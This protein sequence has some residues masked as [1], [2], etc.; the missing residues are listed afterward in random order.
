M[1]GTCGYLLCVGLQQDTGGHRGVTGIRAERWDLL[2]RFPTHGGEHL[3]QR[4]HGLAGGSVEVALCCE[5]TQI[6]LLLCALDQAWV[7]YKQGLPRLSFL[8]TVGTECLLL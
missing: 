8:V 5:V 2:L 4:G 6:F 3:A 1:T 7:L